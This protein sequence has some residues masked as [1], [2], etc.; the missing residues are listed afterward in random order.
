MSS[1]FGIN[2]LIL[3][4][5]NGARIWDS[6]DKRRCLKQGIIR[7]I[8]SI[9]RLRFKYSILNISFHI[10]TRWA[11]T[12]GARKCTPVRAWL[13]N[14]FP[15]YQ[16]YEWNW[17]IN[18]N[19]LYHFSAPIVNNINMP[20]SCQLWSGVEDKINNLGTAL[21][22][23]LM[24]CPLKMLTT[25]GMWE[26]TAQFEPSGNRESR[27]GPPSKSHTLALFLILTYVSPGISQW[28]QSICSV[29][30]FIPG[31]LIIW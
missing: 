3:W 5:T 16:G 4:I 14:P 10:Y 15:C 2:Q 8:T 9:N 30:W 24:G 12:T 19:F 20:I 18:K 26:N 22:R 23:V 28:A 27:L 31:S 6:K 17:N 1:T 25:Q 21:W 13:V 7:I 29:K 11:V